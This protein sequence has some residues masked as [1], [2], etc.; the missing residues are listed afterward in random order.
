MP[1]PVPTPVAAA[2]GLV[3]TVLDGVRRLPGKA[4]SLPIVAVSSALAG[5]DYARREYDDLA[6]RGERLLARLR[7]VSFDE[8]EDRFEDRL[9]G[10][11]LARPY[12]AVEDALEDAGAAV[13]RVAS[14]TA[15]TARARVQGGTKAV[16]RSAETASG[17]VSDLSERAAQKAEKAADATDKAAKKTAGKA[18]GA[19]GRAAA[20]AVAEVAETAGA[21]QDAEAAAGQKAGRAAKK[22]GK[23]AARA[24]KGAAKT[25]EK[26]GGKVDDAAT[27]VAGTAEKA[28][29]QVQQAGQAAAEATQDQLPEAEQP[30]GEATPKA[31]QPDDTPVETAASSDVVDTVEE[32]VASTSAPEVT[33]HDELP[34]PDYDHM[35]LGALR[36][37]LRSLTTEQLVQLRD[38]EKAHAKRLPV[39]TMLDNRIA[40]LA[41][42]SSEQPSGVPSDRPAPGQKKSRSGSKVSPATGGP[43][44]NPPSQGVPTNPAQPRTTG[45]PGTNPNSEA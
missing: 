5:L 39:V 40:K 26:A 6:Q 18:Q 44:L 1:S 28:E 14:K 32:V 17:T 13:S 12:D 25:A 4:I 33:D 24:A 37:R 27:A 15:K 45:S 9:E 31:T 30:K 7:G 3:P 11:P 2:L 29:Q 43:A 8:L 41:T 42:D 21:A 34:L 10:T 16:G 23:V 20:D 22:A 35:T 36:G 38:Y 19:T